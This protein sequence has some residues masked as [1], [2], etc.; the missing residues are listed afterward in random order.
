MA[1]AG[2]KPLFNI[3]AYQL[4]STLLC[5]LFLPFVPVPDAGSWPFLFA[6]VVIHT[7]YYLTLARAYQSGDLSAVYPLFRGLAPLLVTI[8]GVVFAAEFLSTGGVIGVCIISAGIMSLAFSGSTATRLSRAALFWGTSTAMLI[9]LYTI[10]DGLGVRA[11]ENP[12]SYIIWLFVLESIPV[13]IY[14]LVS[15]RAGWIAYI[16]TNKSQALIGGAASTVAYGL[17]IFAMSL[18]AMAIVSALRETSVIFAT[19]IGTLVLKEP[20]GKHRMRAAIIV[21]TGIL[22]MRFA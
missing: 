20:F 6:S 9:S 1:K 12:Y 3:A 4:V 13:T 11:T 2:S 22:V 14:L 7:A 21:V 19:L 8:G 17:V 15:D 5:V 18:G 10:A 16:K